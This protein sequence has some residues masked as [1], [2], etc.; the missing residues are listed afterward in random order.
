MHAGTWFTRRLPALLAFLV[1]ATTSLAMGAPQAPVAVAAPHTLTLTAQQDAFVRGNAPDG[2][3]GAASTLLLRPETPSGGAVP[4]P[5][6]QVLLMFD[7]ASLPA[8]AVVESARLELQMSRG[9]STAPLSAEPLALAAPWDEQSVTWANRPEALAVGLA[10]IQ[11]DAEA[12]WKQ[13]DLLPLAQAWASGARANHGLMLRAT[14]SG[15][16]QFKSREFGAESAPRLTLTYA[17]AN[18]AP[19]LPRDEVP[20]E[21]YRRA[22]QHL[23]WMRGSEMAP[24]WDEA[25]LGPTIRP[26]FRPDIAEAAYYEFEVLRPAAVGAGLEPAGFVLLSAGEHDYPIAHW[27]FAGPTLSAE[28]IGG[29]GASLSGPLKFYK[30]DTLAYAA[31]DAQGRQVATKGAQPARIIGL[32]ANDV[33]PAPIEEAWGPATSAVDD[34]TPLPGVHSSSGPAPANLSFAPWESWAAMKQGFAAAYAPLI[35]RLEQSASAD[36]EIERL[37]GR[38]G[39]VLRVGDVYPLAMLG[40]G[41]P[42]VTVTGEGAAYVATELQQPV[43]RPAVL[44]ITAIRAKAQAA[45][46]LVVNL[47]YGDG[48]SEQIPFTVVDAR[49]VR[50]EG[51]T[52][53]LPVVR[54]GGSA[55]NAATSV[56]SSAP[57]TND[58]RLQGAWGP[59]VYWYAGGANEQRMYDQFGPGTAPNNSSCLS[60]CG[61]TAWAMLFGWVDVQAAKS[62]SNWWQS[63]W[64]IYRQNG[65]RGADA[66]AP[67]ELDQGVRNMV[68][69]I[70]TA[71]GTWC[72][73]FNQN[74]ATFPWSMDMAAAYLIGRTNVRLET[75]YNFAGITESRL[76]DKAKHHIWNYAAPVVIGTGWL[77]HYPLAWQYASRKRV[78]ER[79]FLWQCWKES[80][81]QMWFYVNQGWGGDDDGWVP[82]NTWFAGYLKP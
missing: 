22:A 70:R 71:M 28:L 26:F 21:L 65:G 80:E 29:A 43:G 24:G 12:G 57:Q 8:G 40:A 19:G 7:L 5:E 3:F 23:E 68:W 16:R 32:E 46:E 81:Y 45:V 37:G 35:E 39:E 27:H 38:T 66:V 67:R 41:V 59:W 25:R 76:R 82:A 30:L 50:T 15:G 49:L 36:W 69:E 11:L 9:E 61:P 44:K 64:G 51:Y 34:S 2:N 58:A 78:V 4:L 42:Q 17:L 6:H 47:V 53:Y 62:G 52:V 73:P 54:G 18:P 63:R 13:W 60:G 77:N 10:A 31:E 55:A 79:C 1:A 56:A 48:T 75:Y 20:D 74:A 72:N 33:A 14:G